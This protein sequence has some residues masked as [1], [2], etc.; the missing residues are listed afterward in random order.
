M[1][2]FG[3]SYLILETYVEDLKME[4]SLKIA[5]FLV[6]VSV[7]VSVFFFSFSILVPVSVSENLD[8]QRRGL[9]FSRLCCE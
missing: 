9:V 6:S 2:L 7:S 8:F 3:M 4:S 1:V 5:M